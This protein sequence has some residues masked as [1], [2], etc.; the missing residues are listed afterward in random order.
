MILSDGKHVQGIFVYNPDIEYELGDFIVESDCIYICKSGTPI[1][2]YK[3][4]L[5]PS[6]YK[7]YPGDLITSIDE[8]KKY[9]NDPNGKEDKYISSNILS[10]I[11]Q[12]MYYGFGDTGVIE[13]YIKLKD[14]KYNIDTKLLD[15]IGKG[16]KSI[17]KPLDLLMKEPTVNNAYVQVSRDLLGIKNLLVSTGTDNCLLRQYTYQDLNDLGTQNEKGIYTEYRYRVQELVDFENG[18]S[19]YRYTRGSKRQGASVWQYSGTISSWTCTTTSKAL[20]D[21]VNQIVNHYANERDLED[22]NST[23]FN[24]MNLI[25][26]EGTTVRCT[27]V[28]KDDDSLSEYSSD[29]PSV[30]PI[31][32]FTTEPLI[33]TINIKVK[34]ENSTNVF[35]SHTCTFNTLDTAIKQDGTDYYYLEK[36]VLLKVQYK[37]YTSTGRKVVELS[38]VRS[39]QQTVLSDSDAAILSIY[40]RSNE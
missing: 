24:F 38:L 33:L 37:T 9:L 1:K 13:S 22:N 2:G 5:Y 28:S 18:I 15:L 6:Y 34:T 19:Y 40:Y 30:V 4:S 29:Y 12:D 26:F 3:P 20:L 36:D 35:K 25:L 31:S 16:A 21:K 32:D 10:G 7:P 23:G 8:Y 39:N 11:L 14:S 17:L 27:L